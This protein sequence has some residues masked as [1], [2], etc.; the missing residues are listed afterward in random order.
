[1]ADTY[2]LQES[3][4]LTGTWR[5]VYTTSD[6]ILGVSR[7]RP[8][9]PRPK[10]LQSINA[11]TLTAKNEEW[12]L[13]GLLKNSVTGGSLGTTTRL[14]CQQ[15]TAAPLPPRIAKPEPIYNR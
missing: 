8:F 4:E 1:M 12:V 2:V 14:C 6:S 11:G 15:T 3:P 7:A 13:M 5:L 9:R 10:I